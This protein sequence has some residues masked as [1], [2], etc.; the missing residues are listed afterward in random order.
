MVAI[1]RHYIVGLYGQMHLRLA[2]PAVSRQTTL[3]CIH[4]S[5]M[6]GR[7]FEP[8]MKTLGDDRLV[9]AFDTPGFG[10]SDAP[11]SPPSIEDY[12]RALLTGLDKLA[13]AEQVDVMGYHTGSMIAVALAQ[14]APDRIRRLLMVSAPIF[15]EDERKAFRSHYG[16]RKP[17]ADGGHLVRRWKNF[18]YHYHRPGVTTES[19]EDAF[20]D[21]LLGGAL[22]WWGHQA[23]FEYDLAGNLSGVRHPVLI[24]NTGDDLDQQTRRT[25][26]LAATSL[27]LEVPYWGHGFL[28]QHTADVTQV[29]RTFLDAADQHEFDMLAV[30]ASAAGPRYP[31]HVGSFP[32]TAAEATPSAPYRGS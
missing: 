32:P 2:Q 15:A 11:G 23:A 21:A 22:E 27:V 4:M 31:E 1:E 7:T 8:L 5:P 6:S 25:V 16:P 26:G 3:L 24:L 28:G 10:M 9:L 12:A 14:I 13:I 18:F 17:Q 30:P 29:A 19:V 20:R